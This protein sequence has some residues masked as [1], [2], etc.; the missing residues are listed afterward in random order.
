MKA[1][2]EADGGA[3]VVQRLQS[4]AIQSLIMVI[5]LVVRCAACPE[6]ET[7]PTTSGVVPLVIQSGP[8]ELPG[9][10]VKVP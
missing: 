4:E 2:T 8:P 6:V 7:S 5:E 1:L 3:P 10:T 9:C